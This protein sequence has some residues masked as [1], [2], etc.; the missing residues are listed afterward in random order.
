VIEGTLQKA[1]RKSPCPDAAVQPV[2]NGTNP[3]SRFAHQITAFR[4]GGVLARYPPNVKEG[5]IDYILRDIDIEL[6]RKVKAKATPGA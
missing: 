2:T 5:C 1:A 4:K 3:W 6:W